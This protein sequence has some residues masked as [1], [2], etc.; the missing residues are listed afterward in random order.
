MGKQG[1]RIV[2][3]DGVEV[4][5]KPLEDHGFAVILFN[6]SARPRNLAVRFSDLGSASTARYAVRDMMEEN[7]SSRVY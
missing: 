2:K 1:R 5:A 7:R 3:Q 6:G 4:W